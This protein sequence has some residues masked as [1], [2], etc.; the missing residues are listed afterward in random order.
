METPVRDPESAP[1]LTVPEI[2]ARLS[3]SVSHTYNLLKAGRIPGFRIGSCWRVERAELDDWLAQLSRTGT[4]NGHG[5][6][7][8]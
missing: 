5:G 8:G 7:R 3:L 6:D 4:S 1:L 2:A